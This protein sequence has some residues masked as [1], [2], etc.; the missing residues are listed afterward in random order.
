MGENDWIILQTIHSERNIT[1]AAEKL[2]LS[3]PALTYRLKQIE[4]EFGTK[5]V[6]RGKRGIE[7]TPQG[8]YLVQYA[9]NM[10]SLLR[11]TKEHMNNMDN[12]VR[13]TLR[14]GVS[15]L[16]A[17]YQLAPILKNF[18]AQYPEV[19]INVTTGWSSAV[20]QSVFKEEVHV[21]IIRGD[22]NWPEQKMLLK[23][24]KVCLVSDS[25]VP[26]EDL[27]NLPRINYSTDS[28]LKN[29]IQNWWNE[30]YRQPPLITMEVDRIET[31]LEMVQHGLG[32]GLFPSLCLHDRDN[33]FTADL[34]DRDGQPII[35]KTSLIYRNT[36]TRLS[37]IRA[38]V[39]FL[40]AN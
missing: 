31:C 26:F 33:L 24:E 38:F 37:V 32:Y 21:G 10:L 17:R 15:S 20:I 28:S 39:N 1:K 27:P 8:E 18:L 11:Q 35:R 12:K 30:M 36:A 2:Y 34:L 6:Y 9:H 25:P 19:E 22:H 3:Q 5:I 13:G 40:A 16:F 23:E 29:L 14:L 7:F 4:K